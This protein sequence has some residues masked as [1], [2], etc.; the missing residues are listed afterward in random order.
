MLNLQLVKKLGCGEDSDES[1]S[2]R[3]S[4]GQ[5][6]IKCNPCFDVEDVYITGIF[7]MFQ[8]LKVMLILIPE[9]VKTNFLCKSVVENRC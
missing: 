7:C 3:D 5:D 1:Y 9:S 2:W 4:Y 6:F 8:M